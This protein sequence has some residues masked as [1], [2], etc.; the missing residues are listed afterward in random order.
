MR[1][2][3]LASAT[4]ALL[5]LAAHAALLPLQ[6]FS[7]LATGCARHVA[8]ETLAA[9]A[10]TE[11]GFDVLTLHDNT[12][13][14]TYHTASREEAVA[15]G[16]E[17]ATV[18]RHSIDLGL[19]QINSGNL[20]RL[21]L[22]VADMFDPCLNLTAA[23]RILANGY[24]APAAG[25]DT[26]PAVQQA[27]SRYNTGDPALGVANGYVSRVQASAEVVVPALRVQGDALAVQ[28]TT[29]SGD[30]AVLA[31]PLPPIWDVYARARA[32]HGQVFGASRVP[33]PA[34][35]PAAVSVAPPAPSA[36]AGLAVGQR[37]SIEALNDVR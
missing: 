16:I 29:A 10:R 24:T 14:R 13:G 27:L 2:S 12:T 33:P 17:L 36:P 15:L 8:I 30:G 21:G 37:L 7:Q 31:Q 3:A 28:P 22:S 5:P 26:Q 6:E 9:V 4:A 1:T 23:D 19:M 34:T 35:I 20:P 11:S 32:G 18:G 25:Q